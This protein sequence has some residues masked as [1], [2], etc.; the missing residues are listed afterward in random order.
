MRVPKKDIQ[1]Q[2]GSWKVGLTLCLGDLSLGI[3]WDFALS[4]PFITLSVEREAGRYLQW[5]W[6]M[7]RVVVGRQE[8]RADLT[9][10][11]WS[12]GIVM[13][14]TGDWSIHLGPLHIECE[15]DKF[16]DDDLYTKPAVHLRLFNG[17]AAMR[18]RA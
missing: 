9:L 1:W 3:W 12:L 7:L 8:F 11:N 15:Y 14:Q 6:T 4:L 10:N 13:N 2:V 18:M 17:A 5:D 16:Y